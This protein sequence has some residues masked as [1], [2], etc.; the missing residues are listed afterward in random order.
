MSGHIMGKQ[1][2]WV[3]M[4]LGHRALH[5]MDSR[6]KSQLHHR[7]GTLLSNY[8]ALSPCGTHFQFQEQEDFC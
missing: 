8:Q 4:V 5:S 7:Q 3:R 2:C 6:N 1:H